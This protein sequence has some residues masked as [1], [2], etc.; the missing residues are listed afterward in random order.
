MLKSFCQSW[1]VRN[2]W[3]FSTSI[4]ISNF[5]LFDF[6]TNCKPQKL[7]RGVFDLSGT[8]PKSDIK[9]SKYNLK[10]CPYLTTLKW[11]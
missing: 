7:S 1:K 11:L 8:F 6:P 2:P 9:L 5:T 3:N 10:N 4:K